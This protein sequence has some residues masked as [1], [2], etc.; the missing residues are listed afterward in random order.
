MSKFELMFELNHHKSRNAQVRLQDVINQRRLKKCYDCCLIKPHVILNFDYIGN[1]KCKSTF[2]IFLM[3]LQFL[4]KGN[5]AIEKKV[6]AKKEEFINLQ[7]KV[8]SKF[9]VLYVSYI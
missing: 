8:Y 3:P 2:R 1:E 6:I 4:G 7:T 5:M 9:Y